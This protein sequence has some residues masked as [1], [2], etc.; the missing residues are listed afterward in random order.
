MTRWA[1]AAVLLMPPRDS[2]FGVDK[3]KHFFVA[4]FTQSVTHSALRFAGASPNASLAGATTVTAAA[5]VWK[6]V[7]DRRHGRPFSARDL[8]WDAA[9]AGAATVVARKA[10][11]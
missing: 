1:L 8:V 7:Y 10:L 2:W 9:G 3:V 6:E 5:S 11:R 4:A